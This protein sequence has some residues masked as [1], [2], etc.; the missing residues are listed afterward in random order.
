MF[1]VCGCPDEKF[2]Q[3]CSAVDKLD[4]LPWEDVKTEMLEKGLTEETA[5]KIGSYVQMAGTRQSFS[6]SLVQLG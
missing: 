2:R 6:P 4:K 5:N 3:A 1:A